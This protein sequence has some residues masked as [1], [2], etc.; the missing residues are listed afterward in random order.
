VLIRPKFALLKSVFGA[1]QT[2]RLNRL[3]TSNRTSIRILVE[4]VMVF[5]TLM[6]SDGFQGLRTAPIRGAFPNARPARKT[7]LVEELVHERVERVAA[8]ARASPRR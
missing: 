3:N 4:S 8:T 2:T 1:P 7:P 5:A 6:F